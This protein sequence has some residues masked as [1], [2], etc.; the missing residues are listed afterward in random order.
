MVLFN[1]VLLYHLKKNL[2]AERLRTPASPMGVSINASSSKKRGKDS[3]C[4]YT[5]PAPS[6]S[7]KFEFALN[8]DK[9]YSST[10]P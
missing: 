10:H 4:P 2:I 9:N 7:S 6:C 3:T 1:P 5:L 8:L